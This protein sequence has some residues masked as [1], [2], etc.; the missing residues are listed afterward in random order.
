MPTN[1]SSRDT[2]SK[3][4]KIATISADLIEKATFSKGPVVNEDLNR[5]Q[6]NPHIAKD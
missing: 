3:G 1:P 2:G 6:H 5:H 4:G